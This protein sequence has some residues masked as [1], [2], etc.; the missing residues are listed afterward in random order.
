MQ[1][2]VTDLKDYKSNYKNT[3]NKSNSKIEFEATEKNSGLNNKSDISNSDNYE[4]DRKLKMPKKNS[5]TNLT[6]SISI[7]ISSVS[8]ELQSEKNKLLE[9]LSQDK[10]NN[11]LSTCVLDLK[12]EKKP[13]SLI[14]NVELKKNQFIQDGYKDDQN[15]YSENNKDKKYSVVKSNDRTK[16]VD[17]IDK[18]VCN[19]SMLD[20]TKKSRDRISNNANT[21]EHNKRKHEN[22]VLIKNIENN[23]DTQDLPNLHNKNETNIIKTQNPSNTEL[24]DN[25]PIRSN[26]ESTN[27]P[28][29]SYKDST[30]S[31]ISD[32]VLEKKNNNTD[33]MNQDMIEKLL[34]NNKEYNSSS[35]SSE[36]GYSIKKN[37]KRVDS[38][39]RQRKKKRPNR[40]SIIVSE[41]LGYSR[42]TSQNNKQELA[43]TP[44]S[45]NMKSK[46]YDGHSK[47]QNDKTNNFV[48]GSYSRS[49]SKDVIVYD[50][51]AK[52]IN[53]K[54]YQNQSNQKK[55]NTTAHPHPASGFNWESEKLKQNGRK[56][57]ENYSN[58]FEDFNQQ[59][60]KKSEKSFVSNNTF[61]DSENLKG[62]NESNKDNNI[63]PISKRNHSHNIQ[64]KNTNFSFSNFTRENTIL[65]ENQHEYMMQEKSPKNQ[66][67]FVRHSTFVPQNKNNLEEN[68]K[69]KR[70]D[71][72]NSDKIVVRKNKNLLTPQLLDI[73]ESQNNTIFKH[74]TFSTNQE[75]EAYVQFQINELTNAQNR[76]QETKDYGN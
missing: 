62:I 50:D 3:K 36:L 11:Q 4:I 17:E 35:S 16:G 12:P 8:N 31:N 67:D 66:G 30:D 1:I 18:E 14:L 15:K 27:T 21:P 72:M 76:I 23:K 56:F 63:Y 39:G 68:Q 34:Y 53:S 9:N 37:K 73:D 29:K 24:S 22:K 44:L 7:P 46:L 55:S 38:L 20:I 59:K 33:E 43:M 40:K 71:R 45:Q 65:E 5:R 69:K 41:S 6:K 58:M 32:I 48:D 26:K 19:T 13:E 54:M 60:T 10:N 49:P 42:T 2:E 47:T 51:K 57:N 25:T 52:N 28:I 74:P 61:V 64:K 75:E 70:V